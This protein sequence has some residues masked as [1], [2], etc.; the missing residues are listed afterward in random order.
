MMNLLLYT[1]ES[2]TGGYVTR[3]LH[4]PR[5]VWSQGGAQLANTPEKERAVGILCQALDELQITSSEF[6]GAGNVSSGLAAGIGSVGKREA[7]AWLAKLDEFSGICE[8]VVANFGKKLRVGEGFVSKK[9][10]WGDRVSRRFDKFTN[11]KSLDSPQSHTDGLRK[12][13]RNAQ[14]LDEHTQ[15]IFATPIAEAYSG[16]SPDLRMAIET[17]LKRTSQFF[18]SVVLTFVIRDLSQLLDKYAK[19]C[20]KCLGE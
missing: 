13:F 5:E 12:L 3:R 17:K 7:E 16:L 11:G 19:K 6:F 9:S 20:E 18:A 2:A 10:T 14:L 8:A 4:V 1:M 15:A